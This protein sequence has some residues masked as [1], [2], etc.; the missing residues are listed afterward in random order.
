M[1]FKKIAVITDVFEMSTG[2]KISVNSKIGDAI[3]TN[4]I[5]GLVDALKR[6]SQ[7]QNKRRWIDI[8]WE[9]TA[10]LQT[11]AGNLDWVEYALDELKLE[12]KTLKRAIKFP[13][14]DSYAD[15]IEDGEPLDAYNDYILVIEKAID[16]VSQITLEEPIEEMWD[17][18]EEEVTEGVITIDEL[19]DIIKEEG[20]GIRVFKTDDVESVKDKIREARAKLNK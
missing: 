5:F 19:K 16:E 18:V 12:A 10:A 17:E 7:Y 4:K 1:S 3:F 14:R 9:A 20:L 15:A 13:V 11:E 8:K 2:S 6:N